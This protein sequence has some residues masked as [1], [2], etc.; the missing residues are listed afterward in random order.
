MSKKSGVE[1]EPGDGVGAGMRYVDELHHAEP[2]HV[3]A[4]GTEHALR[5]SYLP[6]QRD[7]SSG[8]AFQFSSET[9]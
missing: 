1:T 2:Y 6:T 9:T 3:R 7:G 4:H 5:I 8:K